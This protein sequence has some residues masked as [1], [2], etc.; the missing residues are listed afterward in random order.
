MKRLRIIL[1]FVVLLS[2]TGNQSQ[3]I[4]G[5]PADTGK[6][7]KRLNRL[8][9]DPLF[10][11]VQFAQPALRYGYKAATPWFGPSFLA[12]GGLM[13][14]SFTRGI[15]EA[16]DSGKVYRSFGS[17]TQ[18]GFNIP[19]PIISRPAFEIVPSIGL[20]FVFQKLDDRRQMG[21][22]QD[23]DAF[24]A[25][26]YLK[27]GLLVKMGPVLALLSYNLNAAYNLTDRNGFSGINHYPALAFYLSAMPV[28][29]NPRDFSASGLRHY[30]DLVGTERVAS[31]MTY[32][33]KVDES[34]DFVKYQ[35]KEIY[36]VKST[37]KHRFEKEI[38][39]VTDVKPFT[40]IGPRI[41]STFFFD[42][43]LSFVQQMGFHAGLR[44]GLWWL[45]T[46]ADQGEILVKSK[47]QNEQLEMKYRSASVPNFSGRYKSNLRIG[48]QLGID[49]IVHWIRSDFKPHYGQEKETQAAT[50][51]FAVVP[52]VGYGQMQLGGFQAHFSPEEQAYFQSLSKETLD[53]P[54]NLAGS[55]QFYNFGL[56]IHVGAIHFGMDY[57]IF[58]DAKRLNGRQAYI[59]LNLP[60]ARLIRS[61]VVKNYLRKI[62]KMD[63]E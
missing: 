15:A 22:D 44:Y 26:M 42:R 37:Y 40:Y 38:I 21:K 23:M 60:I 7:Q 11:G 52:F 18:V 62:R 34:P 56:G 54:Q 29:M 39:H 30:K 2:L 33:K 12:M 36:Y 6:F 53:I 41:A 47:F 4:T 31:G 25:G 61:L 9:R 24:Q 14:G 3:A 10:A 32:W 50:S 57:S 8:S 48:G 55:Q 16:R 43:Q 63:V 19:L 27:P 13:E 17:Q 20:G 1:L 35:K 28:L 58:P 5:I 45:N 49:L 46:F 51:Y 59:G